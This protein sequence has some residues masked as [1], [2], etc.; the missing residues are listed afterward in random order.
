MSFEASHI[1]FVLA[2]YGISGLVVLG[3]V[4]THMLRASRVKQRLS[5]LEAAGAPRRKSSSPTA[6]R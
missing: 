5:E 2:S 4:V 3:L 6:M 1:G